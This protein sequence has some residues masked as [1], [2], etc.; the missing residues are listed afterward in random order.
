MK[1]KEHAEMPGY[2]TKRVFNIPKTPPKK[3]VG[4]CEIRTLAPEGTGALRILNA[5]NTTLTLTL[6]SGALDHSAKSLK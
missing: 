2:G 5:K 6:Q 3:M 4:D 1:N